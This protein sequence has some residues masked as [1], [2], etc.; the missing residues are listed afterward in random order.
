MLKSN[1]CRFPGD[2]L[3]HLFLQNLVMEMGQDFLFQGVL[4]HSLSLCVVN[5]RRTY[6]SEYSAGYP[7]TLFVL[8]WCLD[9]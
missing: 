1:T 8:G 2:W 5:N 3:C 7:K 9:K 6:E 4:T